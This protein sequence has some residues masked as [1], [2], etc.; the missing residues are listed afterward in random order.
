MI[1]FI[2]IYLVNGL[3][4]L[5]LSHNIFH[6]D[7]WAT[8]TW[9]EAILAVFTVLAFWPIYDISFLA[10]SNYGRKVRDWLNSP[11]KGDKE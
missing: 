2:T 9:G 3:I 6:S 7:E 1:W 10:E 4:T 11:M 8:L 5:Y